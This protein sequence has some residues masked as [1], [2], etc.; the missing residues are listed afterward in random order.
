MVQDEARKPAHFSLLRIRAAK[1]G[2]RKTTI[3]EP[4]ANI[5]NKCSLQM[6]RQYKKDRDNCIRT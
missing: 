2:L 6:S 5:T 4:R 3:P 1:R